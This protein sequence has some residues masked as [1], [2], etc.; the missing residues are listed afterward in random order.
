MEIIKSKEKVSEHAKKG[1]MQ[2]NWREELG[3]GEETDENNEPSVPLS[4]YCELQSK[5]EK[6]NESVENQKLEE[7]GNMQVIQSAVKILKCTLDKYKAH[8]EKLN[9]SNESKMK[10]L[11]VYKQ[12]VSEYCK[13]SDIK[14]IDIDLNSELIKI[15]DTTIEEL[16]LK[17]EQEMSEMSA[18]HESEKRAYKVKIQELVEMVKLEK[19]KT[20]QASKTAKKAIEYAKSQQNDTSISQQLTDLFRRYRILENENQDL[21]S[22]KSLDTSTYKQL[23]IISNL[24]QDL[25]NLKVY[26]STICKKLPILFIKIIRESLSSDSFFSVNTSKLQ[27]SYN[28]LL[29]ERKYLLN[30]IQELKGNIRVFCRVRPILTKSEAL[31]TDCA[32]NIVSVCNPLLKTCR[33][34]E[35]DCLFPSTSTQEDIFS[36]IHELVSSSLDGYNVCIFTYGQ[37]GSG[38]TYTLEG[39]DDQPGIISRTSASI[40]AQIK[41]KLTWTYRVKLSLLEVYNETIK[42]LLS[43]K[44]K[45]LKIVNGEISDL[46]KVSVNNTDELV[47]YLRY[48]LDSRAVGCNSLNSHSSRS[49]LVMTLY[50]EAINKKMQMNLQ[51]KI[52]LVDLAGSERLSKTGSQG[53]TLTEAK[54]INL[55]LLA[56]GNVISARQKKLNH[57]PFR[58]SVLTQI[59]QDSLSGEAKTLM[60]LQISPEENNY[61]ETVASLNFATNARNTALGAARSSVLRD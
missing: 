32:G 38:K 23:E 52:Q 40:F 25:E 54:F 49:H 8:I 59:L 28:A 18:N 15:T 4:S 33:Q 35:F 27:T 41:V 14:E 57:V 3:F 11:L 30:Q 37:T 29:Q 16:K 56:L 51:S 10:K 53:E 42:D 55:S 21:R 47:N 45:K 2:Y 50:I 26:I 43:E 48:G 7:K 12:F 1:F 5:I 19:H 13:N 9:K 44:Q 46:N 6:L 20:I 36:E 24:R 61:E 60:I 22:N 34:W 17:Y 31:C 58:N 39:T